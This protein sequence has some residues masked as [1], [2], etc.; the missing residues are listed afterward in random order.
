MTIW[1]E[2]N[3]EGFIRRKSVS[4]PKVIAIQGIG[5]QFLFP[6][7]TK[8]QLVGIENDFLSMTDSIPREEAAAK[9]PRPV[10]VSATA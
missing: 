9:R 7:K 10:L 3:L 1:P 8:I 4:T 6:V 2:R 5:M